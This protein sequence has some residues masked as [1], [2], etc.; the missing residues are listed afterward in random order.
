M[1]LLK[2]LFCF[3]GNVPILLFIHENGGAYT[4]QL[5]HALASHIYTVQRSVEH[6]KG[7]GLIDEKPYRGKIPNVKSWFVLT[8]K[9]ST[10]SDCLI[11]CQKKL[12]K[13]S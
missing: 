9:G 4:K 8:E 13:I 2:E 12:G 3:E 6:L 11:D 7:M 10:V 5:E 1:R